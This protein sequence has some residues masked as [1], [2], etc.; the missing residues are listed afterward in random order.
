MTKAD[1]VE[2]ILA[3]LLE[4]DKLV[5]IRD[6]MKDVEELEDEVLLEILTHDGLNVFGLEYFGPARSGLEDC[7]VLSNV[8]DEEEI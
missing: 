2:A 3:D 5:F 8:S 1:L 6:I 7:M 4:E